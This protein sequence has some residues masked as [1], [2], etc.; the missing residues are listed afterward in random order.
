MDLKRIVGLPREE[1]AWQ[2]TGGVS[3]NG[4]PLHEPYARLALAVPGDDEIRVVRLGAEEYFL[5]GDHRLHSQ[6]CRF[7]GPVLRRMILGRVG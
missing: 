6:D 7:Y 5:L 2:A 4:V 3:I 1:V